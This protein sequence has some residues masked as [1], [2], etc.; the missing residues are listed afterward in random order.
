[1]VTCRLWSIAI[2]LC[3]ALGKSPVPSGPQVPAAEIA[4]WLPDDA[5]AR[6]MF[7][8][9]CAHPPIQA[10]TVSSKPTAEERATL[11][12]AELVGLQV[13][14][15]HAARVPTTPT[16]MDVCFDVE[17]YSMHFSC[18]LEE[19]MMYDSTRGGAELQMV[20][21]YPRA[22]GRCGTGRLQDEARR[23]M[24]EVGLALRS[25]YDFDAL[26]IDVNSSTFRADEQQRVVA[27]MYFLLSS[28][29]PD[30]GSI[31]LELDI[32]SESAWALRAACP[33]AAAEWSVASK[34]ASTRIPPETSELAQKWLDVA[35]TVYR[36]I[37]FKDCLT[38]AACTPLDL[39]AGFTAE[40]FAWALE[41]SNLAN[42]A[43][44]NGRPDL[45]AA[46]AAPA[47]FELQD[48]LREQVGE[49]GSARRRLA[50]Y[51]THDNAI[52]GL[53]VAIGLWDQQWPT[54]A[55]VIVLEAYKQHSA[56]GQT[57]LFRL[58]RRGRPIVLPGCGGRSVCDTEVFLRLGPQE[59]RDPEVWRVRCEA[60]RHDP[61]PQSQQLESFP[62]TSVGTS[63]VF[64]AAPGFLI[65]VFSAA[66]GAAA[67][68]RQT[69]G[70]SLGHP[71]LIA[72]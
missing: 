45:M 14:V 27:S 15:R 62:A 11:D 37:D 51:G 52:V 4:T 60:S 22:N 2:F 18:G 71:L 24:E 46:L 19:I 5:S 42:A 26:G 39:P 8:G 48:V 28:L 30:A 65:A 40:L 1:M 20:L 38:E 68:L 21:Q 29:F 70:R 63:Y 32:E 55:E 6:G 36:P 7:A 23:Q 56:A 61:T 13:L 57:S 35:G 47:I 44:W 53:L 58:L 50:I 34:R 69:P 9:Y 66:L 43:K 10:R 54:Y 67:V 64:L 41:S 72:D 12:G 49:G 31:T 16:R 33:L 3:V 59:L 17:N 25:S